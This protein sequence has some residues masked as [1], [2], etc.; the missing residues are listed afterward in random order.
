MRR[1]S[2]IPFSPGS[3][4]PPE[5]SH[6]NRIPHPFKI[7]PHLNRNIPNFS[8]KSSPLYPECHPHESGDPED[9]GRMVT[10]PMT[11]RLGSG[12]S[13]PG[14]H[15]RKGYGLP[16]PRFRQSAYPNSRSRS[17]RLRHCSLTFTQSSK[18]TLV[19]SMVSSSFRASMP[20]ALIMAPC[21]PT[22]MPF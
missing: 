16:L 21:L 12:P 11:R 18:N 22:R 2:E 1:Q 3:G 14:I 20:M 6:E 19:P 4:K 15:F 10:H 7:Y 13:I 9:K 17:P 8:R 5:E